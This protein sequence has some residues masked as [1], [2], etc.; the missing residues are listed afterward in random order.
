MKEIKISHKSLMFKNNI[1]KIYKYNK[2]IKKNYKV[3]FKF[4]NKLFILL[5]RIRLIN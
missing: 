4:L 1:N 2:D 3:F 5:I